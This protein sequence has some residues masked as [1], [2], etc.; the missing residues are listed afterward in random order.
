MKHFWP[1]PDLGLVPQPYP[2]CSPGTRPP[3]CS[4]V[5]VSH[6]VLCP[7][8]SFPQGP[9]DRDE[10]G[11]GS[12]VAHAGE[13]REQGQNQEGWEGVLGRGREAGKERERRPHRQ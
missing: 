6:P 13:E 5:N 10:E 3:A 7:A 8:A 4:I 9:G 1:N 12:E 11:T 2:L